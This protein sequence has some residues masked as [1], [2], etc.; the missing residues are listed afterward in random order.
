MKQC[1]SL[2]IIAMMIFVPLSTVRAEEVTKTLLLG[3]LEV[4]LWESVAATF[5]H[6]ADYARGD[7]R[8]AL[9]DYED[10]IGTME[11][12]L[13][14]LENMELSA[15]EASA[16]SDIKETWKA[17]KIKGDALIKIDIEKEKYT[18]A[19]DS[20]M[21]DYW[22]DVEKLDHKIDELIKATAGSH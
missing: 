10:D 2:I 21:H 7:Q 17:V 18:P 20:K 11:R 6:I 1:I 8:I 13:S 15:E 4:N 9:E 3:K 5:F 14:R 12:V 16:L 22:L 19:R